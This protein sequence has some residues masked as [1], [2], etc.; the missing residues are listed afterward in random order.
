MT[1]LDDTTN[2]V[3]KKA[4]ENRKSSICRYMSTWLLSFLSMKIKEFTQLFG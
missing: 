3:N 4:N 2:S 1:A